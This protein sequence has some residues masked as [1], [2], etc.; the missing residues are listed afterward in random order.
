MGRRGRGGGVWVLI[1]FVAIGYWV[2][3]ER[4]REQERTRRVE[5]EASDAADKARATDA[6]A[7]AAEIEAAI[8]SVNSAPASD[9][10]RALEIDERSPQVAPE[11]KREVVTA[12]A[13]TV[14]ALAQDNAD[15]V[16]S[17]GP[18]AL[19]DGTQSVDWKVINRS[20]RDADIE[21][22][23]Y[24]LRVG[25]TGQ[26]VPPGTLRKTLPPGYETHNANSVGHGKPFSAGSDFEVVV[27]RSRAGA[28]PSISFWSNHGNSEIPG[29]RIGPRDF[30][31]VGGACAADHD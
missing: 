6:A 4:Q 2:Y 31:A 22:T 8:A 17:S 30:V 11:R 5:A 25:E 9:S 18:F 23:V 7:R 15:C 27:R 1:A 13:A 20:D 12:P 14:P 28:L 21:V 10:A 3:G 26:V 24:Q 29:T 19:P 16:L